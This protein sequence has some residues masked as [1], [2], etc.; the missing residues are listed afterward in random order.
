MHY[1]VPAQ[2]LSEQVIDDLN[3]SRIPFHHP[4][5]IRDIVLADASDASTVVSFVEPELLN[6]AYRIAIDIF[7]QVPSVITHAPDLVY[8][9]DWMTAAA[10]F[11]IVDWNVFV[12]S[13]K[14]SG[15][16]VHTPDQ[17][18]AEEA[19]LAPVRARRLSQ[20][21]ELTFEEQLDAE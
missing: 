8:S 16:T 6:R 18:S 1:L 4:A 17:L 7:D 20:E 15:L 12:E 19:N 2:Q 13:T 14:K 10:G 21:D 11:P 9:Q 5:S 3:R